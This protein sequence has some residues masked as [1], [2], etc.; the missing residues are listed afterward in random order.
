MKD[1]ISIKLE[2]LDNL[3]GSDE[4]A[5][6]LKVLLLDL[7]GKEAAFKLENLTTE[8]TIILDNAL[9]RVLNDE[10][11]QYITGKSWFYGV[12]FF[13]DQ[14]VLIP[15]PETEELVEIAIDFAKKYGYKNVLDI[16][17]GSGCIAVTIK[18]NLPDLDVVTLDVS[19]DAIATARLN[20][21][22]HN[23]DIRFYKDDIL[24]L[25]VKFIE[26]F[27]LIISNPP[28]IEQSERSSMS[29]S[30]LKYEPELALFSDNA[31]QFY[32]AILDFS[33]I[34]ISVKGSILIECNEFFANEIL[35]LAIHIGYSSA[36]LQKDIQGKNRM[37]V[38]KLSE[39]K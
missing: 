30:T 17:T 22:F 38:I 12:E 39:I 26:K 9:Q 20:A 2:L 23:T 4:S 29:A 19:E 6:I 24:D 11:V 37:L 1:S 36:K 27:D 32:R 33:K 16:G 3:H 8:E 10:P 15:R 34:H 13:V 14:R 28:Y 5:S 21:K 35:D 7:L 31:L 25:N 18:K